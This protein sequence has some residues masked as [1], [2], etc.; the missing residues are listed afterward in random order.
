MNKLKKALI[1]FFYLTLHH[2]FSYFD[3]IVYKDDTPYVVE[4]KTTN[5]SNNNAFY[6]SLA[7]VNEARKEPN[8]E[9]VRVTPTEILFMGNPIKDLDNKITGVQ[10][11]N[12]KL[13]PRTFKFEFSQ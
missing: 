12:Y 13:I 2:Q 9:I 4:V 6:I 8:Y 11:R 7:E 1:P 5:N 10:G 3:L